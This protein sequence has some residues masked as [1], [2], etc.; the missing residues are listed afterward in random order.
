LIAHFEPVNAN[1]NEADWT[2]ELAEINELVRSGDVDSI[3]LPSDISMLSDYWSEPGSLMGL[4]AKGSK[5]KVK[6]TEGVE[7]EEE[8]EEGGEESEGVE[9]SEFVPN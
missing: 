7:G 3:T 5:G 4:I 8:K 1:S 2:K 9:G 6:A